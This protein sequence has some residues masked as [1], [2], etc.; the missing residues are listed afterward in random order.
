MEGYAITLLLA[1]AA[2]LI[3]FNGDSVLSV[4]CGRAMDEKKAFIALME[5]V[6]GPSG[7]LQFTETPNGMP[8]LF[9]GGE[10]ASE[11][12]MALHLN[13]LKQNVLAICEAS[14]RV[15]P[16][17]NRYILSQTFFQFQADHTIFG[18][19]S[20]VMEIRNTIASNYGIAGAIYAQWLLQNKEHIPEWCQKASNFLM[21]SKWAA[22]QRTKLYRLVGCIA[23]GAAAALKLG[24]IKFNPENA[25][26]VAVKEVDAAK[27]SVNLAQRKNANFKIC[28][29][30][31]CVA[32]A[33]RR[34]YL[35]KKIAEKKATSAAAQST[36]SV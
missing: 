8:L 11:E 32:R 15:A 34:N 12:W 30:S 18:N 22:E 21:R 17:E 14:Y 27:V 6:W 16:H 23:V 4:V 33:T 25:I 20:L 13:R 24:L 36:E 7:F 35:N 2:P 31:G 29:Q 26:A 28:A 5:S 1:F 10:I 3:H 19:E 9:E